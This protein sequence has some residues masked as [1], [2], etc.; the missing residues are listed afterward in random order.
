MKRFLSFL[1]AALLLFPTL[2]SCGRDKGI[3]VSLLEK[4]EKIEAEAKA[5]EEEEYTGDW[6]PEAQQRR[7]HAL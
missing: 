5:P 2:S 4:A 3:D 7:D 1:L 6:L